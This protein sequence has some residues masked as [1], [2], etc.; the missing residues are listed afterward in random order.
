MSGHNKWS[1]IKHKKTAE[2]AKKSKVFSALAKTITLESKAAGGDLNHPGL[3]AA[4]DRAK[5]ANMPSDNINR[6]VK[7]GAEIEAGNLE[8]VVYE[9][10]GPGGSAIIAEGLTDNKNRTT[11]EIKHLLAKNN[12]NL[13]QPNSTLWV[14]KKV[15]DDW[16]AETL[17]V[18]TESEL[19]NLK[20]LLEILSE[21]EDI[22]KVY[23]NV[24]LA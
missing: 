12:V 10:F 17:M 14:F 3:K 5:A 2:D 22:S 16:Q 21:H 13:G 23:T 19:K 4:I 1:K 24:Q 20:E 6:A 7:K 11:A 18:L 8:L 9:C 15:G